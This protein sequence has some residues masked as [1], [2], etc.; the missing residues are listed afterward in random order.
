MTFTANR[1]SWCII[2]LLLTV[3]F[4][5]FFT[6]AYLC[7]LLLYARSSLRRMELYVLST[8][9]ITSIICKNNVI[10]LWLV[11]M[12]NW[13][14]AIVK[15]CILFHSRQSLS[16]YVHNKSGKCKVQCSLYRLIYNVGL[17]N[18]EW[19]KKEQRKATVLRYVAFSLNEPRCS[20]SCIVVMRR[21]FSH[22]EWRKMENAAFFLL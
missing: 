22:N 21:I 18:I 7:I 5:V 8:N 3:D 16:T 2:M 9:Q 12:T 1:C 10:T 4:Y 11:S 20:G 13:I 19:T 6:V 17:H 15:V 14:P